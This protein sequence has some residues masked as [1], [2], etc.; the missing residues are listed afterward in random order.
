MK[1]VSPDKNFAFRASYQT[2]SAECIL[3]KVRDYDWDWNHNS[4]SQEYAKQVEK[5]LRIL[6]QFFKSIAIPIQKKLEI[7]LLIIISMKLIFNIIDSPQPT[8]LEVGAYF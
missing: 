2:L 7:S 8:F 6:N 5:L 3:V 1:R 4:N